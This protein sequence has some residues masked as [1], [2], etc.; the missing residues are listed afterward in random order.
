MK[1]LDVENE[2]YELLSSGHGMEITSQTHSG[3][4]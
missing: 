4:I 1:E 2:Y 3:C